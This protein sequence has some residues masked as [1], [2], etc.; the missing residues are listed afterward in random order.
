MKEVEYC[1]CMQ[2]KL[3][4]S[5][6]LVMAEFYPRFMAPQGVGCFGNISER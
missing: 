1:I 6:H 5:A 3:W 4:K 2:E